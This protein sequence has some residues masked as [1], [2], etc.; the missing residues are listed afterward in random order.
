L[1]RDQGHINCGGNETTIGNIKYEAD[2]DPGGQSPF[3]G[4]RKPGF[5]SPW[6]VSPGFS[7]PA[8]TPSVSVP[9]LPFYDD[10][11]L[12]Y[13]WLPWRINTVS[14]LATLSRSSP[15]L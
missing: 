12:M 15:L 8:S 4:H 13:Q 2:L 3:L 14:M 5:N 6:V 1:S 9:V 10:L 11:E 7:R